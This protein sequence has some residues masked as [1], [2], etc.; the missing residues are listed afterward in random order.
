M[1]LTDYLIGKLFNFIDK[2]EDEDV[3][4]NLIDV[5][6]VPVVFI[7]YIIH[8]MFCFEWFKI[9]KANKRGKLWILYHE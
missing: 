3:Y 7:M 1:N 9:K 8:D 4:F 2:K 5:F 6:C